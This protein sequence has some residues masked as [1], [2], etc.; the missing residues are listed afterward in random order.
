MSL[1]LILGAS[2]SGKSHYLYET[3]IQS[4][5][6]HPEMSYLILV[7]EQFTMQTQKELVGMH[8][9]G[10]ILNIDVL[11]FQRLA[12]R[13]MDQVGAGGRQ[14]LDETGKSLVLQRVAQENLKQ[15]AYLGGHMKK[16]GYVQEI[17]SLISEFMQYGVTLEQ[18][19]G[20]VDA[21]RERK[22]VTA[23]KLQDIS[24]LYSAFHQYLQDRLIPTEEVLDVLC[25][26]IPRWEKIHNCEIALDGFTGFTP[27]QN[28]LLGVL[29][30]LCPH[31][32]AAVTLGDG[33]NPHGKIQEHQLFA[34]SKKMI[35]SLCG[36]ARQQK[37]E[38]QEEWV[39]AN[40]QGRFAQAPALGFL[41]QEIF[42][43]RQKAY[44]G[45]MG[46]IRLFTAQDPKE[47]MGE[48]CRRIARLVRE[49]G[50]RYGEIAVITGDLASYGS[51]AQQAMEE[52]GIPY[53]LDEKHTIWMNPYVE[54]LR[55]VVDLVRGNYSYEGVFRYLRC[56]M[57]D[58]N[59]EEVDALENYVLALGIRGFSR[60]REKWVRLYRGMPPEE[61]QAL[62]ELRLRFLREVEAFT[63]CCREK[64]RTVE[65]LTRG[66]YAFG[67]ENKMQEK[68]KRLELFFRNR[69]DRAM[70]REYAQIYGIVIHL[71]EKMVDILGAEPMTVAEYQ[72]LLEAGLAEAKV[73]LIPPSGDQVLVGDMERTRLKDIKALFFVGVSDQIIPKN[74]QPGGILS[75]Q[76]RMLFQ[77]AGLELSPSRREAMYIQRFYLYLNLTKPSQCLI[78]SYSRADGQGNVCGPA[79]L[80]DSMKRLFPAL[81]V[82]DV[83]GEDS[84]E[85]LLE[86]P[87]GGIPLLIQ[88]LGGLADGREDP[89]W[90]EL[91]HWYRGQPAYRKMTGQLVDAAFYH[92]PAERIGKSVAKVLYGDPGRFSPTRLE[93]F[94][95]CAFAHYLKYGL[96]L[97]ERQYYEFQAMD[98]GNVMHGALER[99][100]DCLRKEKL[101][102]TELTDEK[103]R[104]LVDACVEQ[105]AADYGSTIL[106]SSARNE[107]LITRIKRILRRTVWALNEQMRRGSFAPAGFE[108]DFPGGRI[109]R[110]DLYETGDKVYVKIIDYKTGNTH[111]DLSSLYY[112]LQLQLVAYLNGA[113]DL[114]R[115]QNPQ[116]DVEPAGIFYYHIKDPL[117]QGQPRENA[118]IRDQKILKELKMDG[119]ANGDKQILEKLDATGEAIPVSYKK[120]GSFSKTS[121]VASGEQFQQMMAFAKRKME[122]LS[123]EILEG[124][125]SVNPYELGNRHACDWCPYRAVCGFDPGVKGYSFQK[126]RPLSPDDCWNAMKEGYED[127]DGLDKRTAAGD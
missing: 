110:M 70:E 94:A 26:C 53:F 119:L 36:M 114:E 41:E 35:A 85:R 57:S 39:P 52:M 104:E 75:E 100:A 44:D 4:S 34:M 25:G 60:W 27:V 109:D 48:V 107:Y 81:A 17:K 88:G 37:V 84:Y 13:V 77:E 2:G 46:D 90:Q 22:K 122:Q 38:I 80:I 58:L 40:G 86:R 66:L 74:R 111:F 113:M 51:Y 96:G 105:V 10:G 42:R 28:K 89:R 106:H 121:S 72:Q 126:L 24:T 61:I 69:G 68:L 83:S 20:A 101:S 93:Q 123:G 79:Y 98:M 3:I 127:G 65:S 71:L 73:G 12:Y 33:E 16:Q 64:G 7:P 43:F 78:L 5:L 47:E 97:Q 76:D 103:Q 59:P 67:V 49:Q 6:R 23:R 108:V 31:V 9:G 32:W 92:A 102:W 118:G 14:I 99:Y 55:A 63:L 8:P 1:H 115:R 112:G 82:E 91:F 29:L 11:S 87:A 15:L 62:N 18:L 30:G 21:L 54:C 50:Y 120:D 45:P 125:T 116:K 56:G 124:E 19:N 95:A 117:I